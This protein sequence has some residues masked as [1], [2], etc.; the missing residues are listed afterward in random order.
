[1]IPYGGLLPFLIPAHSGRDH[2]RWGSSKTTRSGLQECTVPQCFSRFRKREEEEEQ[3]VAAG[4]RPDAPL[5][6]PAVVFCGH[7]LAIF[8]WSGFAEASQI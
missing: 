6:P 3:V 5:D 7:L 2:R 1:M 4:E 8:L